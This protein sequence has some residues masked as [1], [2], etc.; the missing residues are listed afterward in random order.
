MIELKEVCKV[1]KSKSG[2]SFKDLDNFSYSFLNR[3]LVGIYG[4]SGCGKT[5]L[6]NL[7][8]GIDTLTSGD[9]LIDNK[10][11]T[12]F[13]NKELDAYRNQEIGFIFQDDNL[14]DNL[15]VFENVSLTLSLR[16]INSKRR[17]ELVSESLKEDL[18]LN[19]RL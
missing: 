10:S 13:K 19:I 3:G 4:D 18:A 17:K 12:K 16:K 7:I 8:G 11:L 15:N 5:T 9:I 14:I 6:L 2:E 1:Y